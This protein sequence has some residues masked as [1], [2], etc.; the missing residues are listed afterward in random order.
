MTNVIES[1]V[2]NSVLLGVWAGAEKKLFVFCRFQTFH[3]EPL[4]KLKKTLLIF[5][6]KF[7]FRD[8]PLYVSFFGTKSHNCY[9][10]KHFVTNPLAPG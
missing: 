10:K 1:R 5:N 8:P 9:G 6:L 3:G 2:T 7:I 4:K